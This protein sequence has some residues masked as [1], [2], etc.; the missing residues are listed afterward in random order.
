MVVNEAVAV[1]ADPS[2]TGDAPRSELPTKKSTVPPPR[3]LDGSPVDTC[4]VNVTGCPLMD[5]FWLELTTVV[6]S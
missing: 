6:V 2:V 1:P 4:A 5:G 3:G